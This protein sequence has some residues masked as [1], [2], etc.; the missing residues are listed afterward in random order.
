MAAAPA[1][2]CAPSDAQC[3]LKVFSGFVDQACACKDQACGDQVNKELTAWGTEM[4]KSAQQDSKPDQATI[5]QMTKLA[6][7]YGECLTKLYGATT[8]PP[9][10]CG[11]GNPCGD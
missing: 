2:T 1:Q 9:D 7:R 4:A 3:T 10:P 8:P 5:D 11:G 6:Q